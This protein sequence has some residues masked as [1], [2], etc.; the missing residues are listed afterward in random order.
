[1]KATDF[2][3]FVLNIHASDRPT[4]CH[5]GVWAIRFYKNKDQDDRQLTFNMV[6]KF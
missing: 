6:L 5:S 2:R 4:S 3:H 1:M